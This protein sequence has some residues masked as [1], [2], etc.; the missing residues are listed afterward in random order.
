MERA[1]RKGLD[2]LVR[3][4]MGSDLRFS[5]R[6]RSPHRP[7]GGKQAR[8]RENAPAG[9]RRAAPTDPG[10]GP[11]RSLGAAPLPPPRGTIWLAWLEEPPF[12]IFE[13]PRGRRR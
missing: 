3:P 4:E 13:G 7:H 1:G 11:D 10:G 6:I 2:L 5:R 8:G 12:A 9:R